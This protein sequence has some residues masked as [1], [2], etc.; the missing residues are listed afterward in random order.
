M[1]QSRQTQVDLD[2]LCCSASFTDTWLLLELYCGC[3]TAALRLFFVTCRSRTRTRSSG[4]AA[5]S[6]AIAQIG[7]GGGW[8]GMRAQAGR[9]TTIKTPIR[10]GAP[11]DINFARRLTWP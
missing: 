11:V 10:A 4:C 3:S 6:N 7:S 1:Q 9:Q 8:C 5:Y 2:C